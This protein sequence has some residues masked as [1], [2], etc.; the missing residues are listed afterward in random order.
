MFSSLYNFLISSE[1]L[2]ERSRI[3]SLYRRGGVV[4]DRILNILNSKYKNIYFE[5]Y[6]LLLKKLKLSKLFFRGK[7][8]YKDY[9]LPFLNWILI[10]FYYVPV[11][12]IGT[13]IFRYLHSFKVDITIIFLLQIRFFKIQPISIL[14]LIKSYSYFTENSLTC[15]SEN[16]YIA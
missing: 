15:C 3:P 9:L 16:F 7:Y 14:L 4:E 2:K 8:V 13:Y 11:Y 6:C 12:E 10:F 5:F 1:N